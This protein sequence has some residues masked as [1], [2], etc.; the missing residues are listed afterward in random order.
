MFPF[1]S[2]EK[3]GYS[4]EYCADSLKEA[5]DLAQRYGHRLTTHPGQFTQLGSPRDAV[6]GA[7]VRELNYH[8]QML[9]L[10]GID[11]DG[12]MVVHVGYST[13]SPPRSQCL[14][15]TTVHRGVGHMVIKMPP[16]AASNK[17][18]LSNFLLRSGPGLC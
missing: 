12:V 17:L 6:R 18:S 5:G 16:S 3:H 2:H 9:D 4:L 10:M 7:A 1:A 13:F 14:D 11:R 15:L 8:S